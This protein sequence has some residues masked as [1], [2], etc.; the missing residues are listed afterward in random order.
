MKSLGRHLGA[1]VASAAVLAVVQAVVETGVLAWIYRGQNL[2]P[3]GFFPHQAYDFFLKLRFVLDGV[4]GW[5]PE[6]PSHFRPP[7]LAAHAAVFFDVLVPAVAVA[8]V[9]ALVLGSAGALSRRGATVFGY[10]WLWALVGMVVHAA[11]AVPPLSLADNPDWHHIAYRARSFVIDGTVAAL[12][13]LIVSVV[14]SRTILRRVSERSH[15]WIAVAAIVLAAAGLEGRSLGVV[16]VPADAHAPAEAPRVALGLPGDHRFNVVLISLDSLRA[17]HVGCYGY[18]RATTPALDRFA[19]E[20]VRFANAISTSSWTLPTHLTMFTG[21]YQLSHG[22]VQDT[23]SLR[24]LVPT[25]PEVFKKN[26]YTTAGFVSGPYLAAHYGYARGMDTY[27]DISAEYAHRQEARSAIVAPEVTEKA[28]GWLDAHAQDRFFLFIHYFD[29]HYD[30]IPPSPYD[31]MFDP[32]YRG[33]IDGSNFIE[34]RDVN[35]RMDARDLEHI[36]ALYDG[37][38]RFTDDHV[39]KVLQRIDRLGLR[40][41]TLV[42]IVSDHGDEF[43]EHGNKG[44]HR[45]VYSEVLRVPF[46]MRLPKGIGRG[47]VVNEQVSLVDLMPTILDITGIDTPRG[48][49]GVSLLPLVRGRPIDREAIY[50]E[51]FDKRGFN[52]QVARRTPEHKTIEHFNRLM[53][54]KRRPIEAYDLSTDPRERHDLAAGRVEW[55]NGEMARLGSWLEQRWRVHRELERADHGT[56]R[57]KIDNETMQRLKSL[58][59]VGD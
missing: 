25:L 42:I 38:I 40:D 41:N 47:S 17:D 19:G 5:L 45:T 27:E 52:L 1:A 37:E 44:H 33:T 14:C 4:L 57:V 7:S 18:D 22:V 23:M 39:A 30:Y 51:F 16:A 6:L 26:G 15:P 48:V 9:A 35:S 43:F 59:Y 10:L 36:L 32:D 34:R 2:P 54:P 29:I 31:T 55:L 49:E 46:L 20:G 24:P 11:L 28:L 53:H 58:G 3:Y 12:G 8:L 13:V 50:A 21:R 56:N